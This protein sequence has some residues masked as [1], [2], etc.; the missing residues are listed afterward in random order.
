MAKKTTT[1]PRLNARWKRWSALQLASWLP[2]NQQD[3]FEVLD[4]AREIITN[5]PKARKNSQSRRINPR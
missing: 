3:A 2:Q 1:S 4:Q 5:L